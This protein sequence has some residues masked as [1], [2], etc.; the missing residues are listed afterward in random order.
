MESQVYFGWYE[1]QLVI[2]QG[3]PP[4]MECDKL[5]VTSRRTPHISFNFFSIVLLSLVPCPLR[6]TEHVSCSTV[7]TTE[8]CRISGFADV[9][10]EKI[11]SHWWGFLLHS[12]GSRFECRLEDYPDWASS[13]SQSLQWNAAIVPWNRPRSPTH[14]K[15]RR[16]LASFHNTW[17]YET[18]VVD[19]AYST[20]PRSIH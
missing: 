18:V 11:W 4:R 9:W 8:L 13:L 7:D 6:N 14:F 19:I 12:R 3:F 5:Y 20:K 16:N 15:V 1:S 17:L 10:P 2:L